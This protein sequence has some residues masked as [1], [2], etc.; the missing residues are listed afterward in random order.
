MAGKVCPECGYENEEVAIYCEECGVMFSSSSD[1]APEELSS[2]FIR[3]GSVIRDRYE[4][5]SVLKRTSREG[6]Y[7]AL[8]REKDDALVW[9]K[10]WSLDEEAEEEYTRIKPLLEKIKDSPHPNLVRPLDVFLDGK[11]IFVVFENLDG[12][13]LGNLLNIGGVFPERVLDWAI[14]ACHGLM[15]LHSLGILHRDIQ[16]SHLFLTEDGTLKITGF[17]RISSMG[18]A[19]FDNSVT[20][21]YSPPEAYGLLGGK[22]GKRSDIFS[23]GASLYSLLA[24]KELSL[25]REDFFSFPPFSS[26]G[27]KVDAEMERIILKCVRKEPVERYDSVEELMADLKKLKE[28]GFK[29][30]ESM[31]FYQLDVYA[32]SDVGMVRRTNQD[33]YLVTTFNSY[34]KSTHLEWGLFVVA[35]GMGGEA[36]GDKASSIAI[37]VLSHS[38]LSSFLPDPAMEN[39][40]ILISEDVKDKLEH[41]LRKAFADANTS[42]YEY[43]RRKASRRGMGCTISA[44][45]IVGDN[46]CIAHAGDT[47]V[48]LYNCSDGLTQVTEDHSLVGRLVQLGQLTREEAMNSPQRNAVYRAM[49]TTKQ[50]EVD[51]YHKKVK[52]GDYVIICSDGVWEY[53]TDKEMV[54][55]IKEKFTPK[56]IVDHFIQTCLD[57]GADDNATVIV[58]KV[59]DWDKEHGKTELL[60]SNMVETVELRRKD[61]EEKK[62]LEAKKREK[63]LKEEMEKQKE[64]EEKKKKEE[65]SKGKKEIPEETD[66]KEKVS[67]KKGEGT[68]SKKRTSK[69]KKRKRRK[70]K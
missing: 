69:K 57:R 51:I 53:F 23:L 43:S 41:V 66:K 58:L 64:R 22:I 12:E 35:D 62:D 29:E 36:E 20:D 48:Y 47:R 34:E 63:R 59:M 40:R 8:D 3:A 49:G 9:V 24:G 31:K 50:L 7:V 54:S 68:S 14:Q 61:K 42:V 25:S 44:C 10:Q 45:I 15:H 5:L 18:E 19:V 27:K 37:K 16:P 70:R 46:M 6:F 13:D 30:K 60:S 56:K 67:E 32:R 65:E 4:V 55:I 28:S 2:D 39:T 38:V 33:A 26:I 21:G 1:I 17:S 52:P 11:D